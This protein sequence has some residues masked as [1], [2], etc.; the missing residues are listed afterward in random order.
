MSTEEKKSINTGDFPGG[1]ETSE[2]ALQQPDMAPMPV[3]PS[4]DTL[5]DLTDAEL[6]AV[7][8]G[9]A[10]ALSE[11][12]VS[13]NGTGDVVNTNPGNSTPLSK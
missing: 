11:V 12:S 8:G 7:I 6:E 5:Q 9:A 3:S 13:V 10:P 4:A 1:D 2:A